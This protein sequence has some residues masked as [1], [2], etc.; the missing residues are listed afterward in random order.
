MKSVVYR[1]DGG[2]NAGL[3]L[4]LA[5]SIAGRDVGWR[6]TADNEGVT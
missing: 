4:R 5:F 1:C 2:N 3:A 6:G